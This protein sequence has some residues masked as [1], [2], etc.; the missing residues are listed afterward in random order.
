MVAA[1]VSVD[2]PPNNR[3]AFLALRRI[4][5]G[6][7]QLLATHSLLVGTCAVLLFNLVWYGMYVSFPLIDEDGAANYSSLIEAARFSDLSI[8]TFPIK[9]LEGLGQPNVF[10]PLA[11]DPFSWL[12]VKSADPADAFRVSYA[13]RATVCWL[14]TYLLAAKLFRGARGLAIVSAF[15][16]LDFTFTFANGGGSV[17]FAGIAQATQL[18]MLPGLLWLYLRVAGDRRWLTANDLIFALALVAF[19]LS[20]PL[21]S[22]FGLIVILV[23]GFS[24]VLTTSARRRGR[25]WLAWAKVLTFSAVVLLTPG[26]GAYWTWAAVG[27]DSARLVFADELSSYSLNY[28]VPYFWH[29][30]PLAQGLVVVLALAVLLLNRRWPSPLRTIVLAL[31]LIVGGSQLAMVARTAGVL[32]GLLERLPRPFYVEFYLPVFYSIT[33]AYIL[34]RLRRP[35]LD[36]L[37]LDATPLKTPS[38]L[39]DRLRAAMTRLSWLVRAAAFTFFVWQV[40]NT[41]PARLNPARPWLISVLVVVLLGVLVVERGRFRPV[42]RHFR[43]VWAW[44]APLT[45]IVALFAATW[46]TWQVTPIKIH[47]L[48]AP[49]IICRMRTPWCQDP[50][51]LTMGAAATPVTEYLAQA[52]PLDG[53]FHGRADYFLTPGL[54]LLTFPLDAGMP[55]TQDEFQILNSWYLR[56]MAADSPDEPVNHF[57][58]ADRDDLIDALQARTN[59]ALVPEDVLVEMLNWVYTYRPGR[60]SAVTFI[61]WNRNTELDGMVRERTLN[62]RASGNGML[63][64]ALPFQGIPVASSYEQ[65]LDYLYYLLWTRYISEGFPNRHSINMTTLVDAQA[66]RLALVG[67]R[68]VVAREVPYLPVPDL[69]RMWSWGN[70]AVHEVPN[71]NTNGY[72]VRRLDF[73]PDLTMELRAM[74]DPSFNPRETAVL[75]QSEMAD[76]GDGRE[77]SPLESS[78]IDFAGQ[79]LHI[80]ANSAGRSLMVVPFKYSHCWQ[81]IWSGAAGGVHRVDTSL[82]GVVFDKTVDLTLR[83]TAGYGP[84]TSCLQQDVSLVPQARLAAQQ[85]H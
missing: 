75:S 14:T 21:Q 29:D 24:L 65:S 35:P 4:L 54:A 48:F 51:G 23:F 45:S 25:P 39:G 85:L 33:A 11:F 32:G 26:I 40:F 30:V 28:E 20:Y 13:L 5:E 66:A 49:D 67:V 60:A 61:D 22:L 84:L 78:Q 73:A 81:P 56:S 2:E 31:T 36:P 68:F 16:S 8:F 41:V 62:Y 70:Y 38:R 59:A 58:Y 9:W 17:T 18:A 15:I 10:E 3:S 52:L 69:P 42:H 64:R 44:Y 71:P 74:R 63:L 79:Q 34:L 6:S 37:R 80:V 57:T 27:A 83:W 47:P 19:L 82:I 50:P 53:R 76:L 1:P 7:R 43:P 77:L 12:M 55:I 72:G 46:A